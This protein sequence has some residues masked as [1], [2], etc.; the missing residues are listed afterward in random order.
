MPTTTTLL[1]LASLCFSAAL[2]AAM[3]KAH[4]VVELPV[5]AS[6]RAQAI[7][8]AVGLVLMLYSA[9]LIRAER[10]ARRGPPPTPSVP[11]A[12]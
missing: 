3:L 10:G 8:V 5:L 11:A 6:R 9:H 1:V 2:L 7:V 4:N 12:P